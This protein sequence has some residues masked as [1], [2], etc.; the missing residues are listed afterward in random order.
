MGYDPF[1]RDAPPVE[2]P[3]PLDFGRRETGQVAV[4]L[5]DGC[6]SNSGPRNYAELSILSPE[7]TP[8]YLNLCGLTRFSIPSRKADHVLV[9]NGTTL[10]LVSC[11]P[12]AGHAGASSPTFMIR[13]KRWPQVAHSYS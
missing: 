9:R 2:L 10:F 6:S 7:L 4:Y 1:R 11:T 3:D 12:H 13:S 8:I 5:L